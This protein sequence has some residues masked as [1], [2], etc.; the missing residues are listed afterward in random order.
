MPRPRPSLPPLTIPEQE[1]VEQW[2]DR[3]DGSDSIDEH[4]EYSL[5]LGAE[6]P[7]S[8]FSVDDR[9]P[10]PPPRV[11]RRRSSSK[12]QRKR[13]AVDR[14]CGICFEYAVRPSR[15]LCCGNIFCSEHITDW[16]HGPSSDGR[17]PS[18]SAPCST[19]NIISL[20]APTLVPK[21]A[22]SQPKIAT[23]ATSY[24]TA[25]VVASPV[26][27]LGTQHDNTPAARGRSQSTST[28]TS[29]Q[30][31][32]STSSLTSSV[33]S[34]IL[35][36]SPPQEEATDDEDGQWQNWF[37]YARNITHTLTHSQS[38]SSISVLAEGHTTLQT[39]SQPTTHSAL[40]Q[41]AS[42]TVDVLSRLAS[43]VGLTLLFY[44]LLAS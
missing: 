10:T 6:S 40:T 2:L 42:P 22:I 23:P 12:I 27:D 25:A 21:S 43:I 14:D 26:V 24:D 41:P 36:L 31:H 1:L 9:L 32:T 20:V 33:D 11:F 15:T 13:D 3:F 35:G 44:V 38:S 4:P 7:A 30:S 34:S 16:L 29:K 19:S 5:N 39:V 37:T 18:C 28:S 8:S 17:C